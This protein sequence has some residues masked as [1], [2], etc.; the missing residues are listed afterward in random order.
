MI[1]PLSD[2]YKVNE[3]T[4][5]HHSKEEQ[6]TQCPFLSDVFSV[7]EITEN[8][9]LRISAYGLYKCF[10]NGK[11]ITN[12]ILTPGWVN[13]D[14]RLPYQT[15][16]VSPFINKGKNTIQIW[17]ADGWY[18]GAL[19][20]LQ[21]GLKVSN[22]WGNKL[23]AIVEIRN[24]KKILLTSNE[25]WKSGLL[26]ILKSGIYYGEEY[27]ANITPKETDGVAVLDFDKSFLIEHEIDPVKELDPINV[28]EE[29]KD[30]EG[31]TIYD[32]GQNVAGYVSLELSGNKD[33]KHSNR[34]F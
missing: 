17:L 13:Y 16:N 33:S 11:N 18:R 25:N 5:Y 2:P 28:Q 10:I 14:D 22:V 30:D 21:T 1:S 19:M 29:L 20:S 9:Q 26:P 15:Y 31:F 3:E 4:K 32:F 8:E 7:D 6:L 12:D 34:T 23:G 27:N 24:E